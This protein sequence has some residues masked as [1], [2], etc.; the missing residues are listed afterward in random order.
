MT[1]K[2]SY[3]TRVSDYKQMTTEEGDCWVHPDPRMV[4]HYRQKLFKAAGREVARSKMITSSCGNKHC[5]NPDHIIV[6]SRKTIALRTIEERG[7]T[8]LHAK[9]LAVAGRKKLTPELVDQIRTSAG[10]QRKIAREFGVSQGM[11]SMLITGKTWKDY[12][13][14]FQQ[15]IGR[16]V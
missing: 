15:L 14:P 10:S 13:N 6:L 11:I 4:R 5:M 8:V 9:K 3:A 2:K 12:S 16:G 1:A 7:R